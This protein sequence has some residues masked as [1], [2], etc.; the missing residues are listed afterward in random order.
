[1]L[2]NNL[3]VPLDGGGFNEGG[4]ADAD[5]RTHDNNNTD[6]NDYACGAQ[7]SDNPLHS[8]LVDTF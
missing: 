8:H 7:A 2:T 5:S 1:M 4:G 6:R 3:G